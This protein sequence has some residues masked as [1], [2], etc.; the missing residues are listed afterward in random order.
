M[1]GL[2]QADF[3]N[4]AATLDGRAID[5]RANAIV[6]GAITTAPTEFHSIILGAADRSFV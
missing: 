6:M 4:F 5:F 3:V 2:L 1:C